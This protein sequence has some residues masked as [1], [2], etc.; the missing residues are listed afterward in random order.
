[1]YYRE[2]L[3]LQ[4]FL[5]FADDD[6]WPLSL[7]HT[8]MLFCSKSLLFMWNY[9]LILAFN[10]PLAAIFGGYRAIDT[11]HRNYKTLKDRAQALA[12]MKF[13]YVVSCQVYGAQKMSSDPRERGHYLNILSLMLE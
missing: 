6:G 5:D 10:V 8:S 1:M 3:E 2:A 13:T 9:L 7:T 11:T 12:D 4:C